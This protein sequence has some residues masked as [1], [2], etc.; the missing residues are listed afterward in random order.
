MNQILVSEKV[1]VTPELK[2]KRKTYKI[3]FSK[4][5]ARITASSL[6]IE[7]SDSYLR[8]IPK[9]D[10]VRHCG[11]PPTAINAKRCADSCR[12]QNKINNPVFL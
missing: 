6:P 5:P 9:K 2:R 4:G 10:T 11:F 3:I 12:K 1:Y 8:A 7:R